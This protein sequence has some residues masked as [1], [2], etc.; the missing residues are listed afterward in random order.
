MFDLVSL[1]VGHAFLIVL[2]VYLASLTIFE[3]CDWIEDVSGVSVQHGSYFFQSRTLKQRLVG[4]WCE[5]LCFVGQGLTLS[6]EFVGSVLFTLYWPVALGYKLVC[7]LIR[8]F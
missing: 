1:F 7:S 5:L 3:V 2:G 8:R 4:L 6:I